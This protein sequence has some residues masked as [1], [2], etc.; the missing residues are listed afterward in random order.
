MFSHGTDGSGAKD[1]IVK[2]GDVRFLESLN[3]LEFDEGGN[4][5]SSDYLFMD[6]QEFFVFTLTKVPSMMKEVF[7]KNKLQNEDVDLFVFHQANKYM[8]AHLRKKAR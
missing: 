7:A 4:P 1:L 8:L 6:G 2:T 5:V 3:D